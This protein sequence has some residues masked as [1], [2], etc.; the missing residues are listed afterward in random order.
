MPSIYGQVLVNRYD[1][2]QTEALIK[3]GASLDAQEIALLQDIIKQLPSGAV[4]V[5]VGANFGLY[6][7]A[8][9]Q[10]LKDTG[11]KVIAFEAQ[12][13]IFNMICGS[14]ALNS[15]ENMF[16]HHLAVSDK[17]GLIDIPKLD[18]NKV[19][20]FGS[21]EF[22]SQQNEYMGQER[23]ESTEQVRT[24]SLD[25]M[26]LP[27][28]DMIKIDIEGMEELALA[29]ATQLFSVQR[30]IA[31]VEWIKSDK[32]A[33][34]DY[35]ASREYSVYDAGMNLLCIPKNTKPQI[36]ISDLTVLWA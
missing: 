9:A 33:I 25:E 26:A 4:F 24:V 31:Y 35:F 19:S 36:L 15:L 10:T 29:G 5:D 34:V 6:S 14:V 30:P 21:V 16:V 32:Q 12:R 23:G 28:V 8:M 22:G 1:T 3:T 20:S 18:Y 11:G 27:R 2:F 13:L 7:L 17:A